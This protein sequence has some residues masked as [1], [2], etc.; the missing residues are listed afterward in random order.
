[1]SE[2]ITRY[3]AAYS[4]TGSINGTRYKNC[5]GK[6]SS[7][8]ATGNDYAKSSGST[9]TITY[10][11]D[12][13][14]I[15]ENAVIESVEVK[16]GGHAEANT[17]NSTKKCEFQLYAGDTAKGEMKHFTGTSKQ[18]ITLPSGTWTRA[19]LQEAKLAVTIGYYG[20]LVNG[21]DFIVTYSIPSTQGT[22]L[23]VKVSGTY[24]KVTKIYRK[25]GGTWAEV[26]ADTLDQAA[27]Y[28]LG[29]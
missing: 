23:R 7:T 17:Y 4:V 25:S 20:G 22:P 21:V 19:E 10:T 13:S 3:P 8:T 2:T 28:V 1:M 6:G 29:S 18:V 16:V 9:A 27:N 12:F 15:P 11:F 14:D 26:D 24:K 5:I